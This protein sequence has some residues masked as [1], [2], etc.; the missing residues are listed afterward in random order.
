[1]PIRLHKPN[2]AR[3]SLLAVK[4]LQ[5]TLYSSKFILSCHTKFVHFSRT[6]F[7][8][9]LGFSELFISYCIKVWGLQIEA[10]VC[11]LGSL[12]LLFTPT[13]GRFEQVLLYVRN[14]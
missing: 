2:Q 3:I 10:T 5:C 12:S 7:D 14:V 4:L 11:P 8:A 6:A 1:M 9:H 13:G